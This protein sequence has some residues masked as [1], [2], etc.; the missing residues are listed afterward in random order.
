MRLYIT[1]RDLTRIHSFFFLWISSGEVF[2]SGADFLGKGILGS[3]S[4]R[5]HSWFF[6]LVT[7]DSWRHPE[8]L[9]GASLA[10]TRI[11][12]AGSLGRR[13]RI[14][15]VGAPLAHGLP[16]GRRILGAEASSG[17]RILGAFLVTTAGQDP[18]A[19]AAEVVSFVVFA[20]QA[21]YFSDRPF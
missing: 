7:T 4:W 16:W 9:T 6:L 1:E 14:L 20:F 19:A 18:G 10:Q 8:A 3:S 2:R 21:F 11:L 17:R 13:G 12:G 5:R 15:G